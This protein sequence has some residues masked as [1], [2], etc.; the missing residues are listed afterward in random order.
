MIAPGVWVCQRAFQFRNDGVGESARG[1]GGKALG[2]CI[3]LLDLFARAFGKFLLY[4]GD[5]FRTCDTI[6]YNNVDQ[7]KKCRCD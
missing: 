3:S 1:K 2:F 7:F 6:F 5:L 4:C